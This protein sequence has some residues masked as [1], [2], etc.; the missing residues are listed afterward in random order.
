[1]NSIHFFPM[2]FQDKYKFNTINEQRNP[3][4]SAYFDKMEQNKNNMSKFKIAFA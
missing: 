3:I 2:N 4:Q 1:M